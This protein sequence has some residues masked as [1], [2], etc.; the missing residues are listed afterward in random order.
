MEKSDILKHLPAN[1]R[2][3]AAK[4]PPD[5]AYTVL[6]LPPEG[7]GHN[8]GLVKVAAICF[9]M[10][11]S[12]EDTLAHLE[13]IYSPDRIDYRTA[14]RR[15]VVRIWEHDGELPDD[16]DRDNLPDAQEE[17]LLRFRRTPSTALVEASPHKV[18]MKPGV[19]IKALFDP[20]DII[21]IQHTGMEVG[22]LVKVS[23]LKVQYPSHEL[24][25]YKFLNPSTF[26]KVEGVPNPL[27]GDKV[28]TRCNANV[29]DRPYM[30]LEMDSKDEAQVER[31]NTFALELAKFAPLVLAVDTGNKSVHFWFDARK[32]LPKSV[33]A[34]FTLACLHGADKRMGV[35]SQIARMPNVSAASEG[36]GA[37][38]VLYFDPDRENTPEGGKWNLAGFEDFIQ[39]ARQLDYYYTGDSG[40]YFMQSNSEAWIALNRTSLTNQLIKQGFRALKAEGE[41]LSPVESIITDIEMD[42]SIEAAMKGASGRHAGYYEENGIRFLVLKSPTFIKPRK[43]NWDTISSFFT[44]MLGHTSQQLDVFYGWLSQSMKDQRNNG[45]RRSLFSPAQMMHFIGDANS[46]KTLL[47]KFILPQCFGNRSADADALFEDRGAAFNSDMFQSEL[48]YLDDSDVLQTDHKFRAKFGERIKSFTV[49]AGGSYHQKFGDKVPVAP[50]WRFVRMMNAEPATIATLPP[51]ED[52]IADKLILLRT[53]SMDGGP[54][55]NTSPGWFEPVQKAIALELPAFIQFL[56]EEYHI[57]DS[58]TDPSKRYAVKSYHNHAVISMIAEDSPEAYLIHKVDTDASSAMFYPAFDDGGGL[59]EPWEGTANELYTLLADSG[60]RNAQDR[61][62]KTCPSPKVLASQLRSVLKDYP[63]RIIYSGATDKPLNPVKRAGSFYWQ[64]RPRGFGRVVTETDCF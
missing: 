45:K 17:L 44:H 26:K 12:F 31:F 51:L 43:G 29:K 50:W 56:L 59:P 42:K 25:T 21:N 33:T 36:R 52:G 32:A 23:D 1:L 41:A 4:L 11:V 24:A 40:K 6:E 16:E 62:R 13:L 20:D 55:D 47:L 54:I 39:K 5:K 58:I 35:R 19:V 3:A 37:Q 53:Q 10:G 63:E 14:P 48:L 27:D 8:A 49:G 18:N 22:T 7:A 57:P 9:R 15:A 61:F 60:S 30:V 34:I 46:G 64:I 38:R 28:A 2:A